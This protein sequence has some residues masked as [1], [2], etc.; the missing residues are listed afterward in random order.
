MAA[1]ASPVLR[2]AQAERAREGAAKREA[3]EALKAALNARGQLPSVQADGLIPT[4]VPQ[5]DELLGGGLPPGSVAAVEGAAGRWSLAAGIVAG[6]TRRS[7]VAILDDGA[8]Y[9]PALAEAGARLDR[10]MIVP[11][12]TPYANL[13]AVDLL[14]RARVCRMVLMPAVPV[15]DAVWTRLAK[16][17]H[18]SGVV[19]L[20]IAAR[21]GA[22]LRASAE[23]CVHCSAERV[24]MR[25][26]HGLWSNF[27][28]FELCVGVGK[29][30]HMLCGQTAY[31]DARLREVQ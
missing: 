26:S 12:G 4:A 21:A 3:F 20:V 22:S 1:L 29:H 24:A 10:I 13:R 2:P 23:L 28:G 14:L 8:L 15:R 25:G 7:L 17:A 18:R 30:R 27:S 16:L 31:M 6:I 9:P 11:A 19:L 5:L